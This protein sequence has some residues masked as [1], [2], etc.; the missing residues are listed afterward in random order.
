MLLVPRLYGSIGQAAR[1]VTGTGMQRGA[2][3]WLGMAAEAALVAT[4]CWWLTR[5]NRALIATDPVPRG[6]SVTP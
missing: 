2:F 1:G 6:G 5:H 4:A 3:D